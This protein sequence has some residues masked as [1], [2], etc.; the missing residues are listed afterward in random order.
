MLGRRDQITLGDDPSF[1]PSSIMPHFTINDD[2]SPCFVTGN[3]HSL[4]S[5]KNKSQSQLSPF[6]GSVELLPGDRSNLFIGLD[7]SQSPDVPGYRL[8]S[9]F[10]HS[11][12]VQNT[13]LPQT[14]DNMDINMNTNLFGALD[15]FDNFGGVEL[16]IDENGAVILDE[17]ELQLPV[18]GGLDLAEAE[19]PGQ[20]EYNQNKQPV[21]HGPEGD[22]PMLGSDPL[23]LFDDDASHLPKS[24][25]QIQSNQAAAPSRKRRRRGFNLDD[26]S[27]TL[28]R[29]VLKSWQEQYVDNAETATKRRKPTTAAQ[30]RNNA[31]FFILG[32]GIGGA[33]C[34]RGVSGVNYPLARFF[35]GDALRDLVFGLPCEEGQDAPTPSPKGRRRRAADAFDE[36]G[37]EGDDRNVRVR[38]Y[39]TPQQGRSMDEEADFAMMLGDESMPEMGMEAAEPM[40]EHMSS[41]L[42]PWNRTPSIGR[43]S[44]VIG[45][46]AQ[47]HEQ[48][49]RQKSASVRGSSIPPFE[50]LN[51]LQRKDLG[52]I[53]SD[54]IESHILGP[55][56]LQ[57]AGFV[58]D[59]QEEDENE[60]EWTRSNLESASREF[61][62]WTEEEAKTIGQVKEGD[63][64]ENRR[65]VDFD[66]L[67]EPTKQ[68]H[69]VAAQA[70]YHILSLATKNAISVEQEVEEMQAFGSIRIGVDMKAHLNK[71]E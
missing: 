15:D 22:V 54:M 20:P 4:G 58:A 12:S 62:L 36:A 25:D 69:V 60:S 19:V 26:E 56:G 30:A 21:V 64:N 63:R 68:N 32:Q 51:D 8:P 1:V 41:S 66:S 28:S 11:S 65:W 17:D 34:H 61:L 16:V 2:G 37:N 49:S 10:R 70:F 71:V 43:G 24:A 13:L 33:G 6:P 27:T 47:R 45:H 50:P 5:G 3:H 31:Y 38:V 9:P 42:M 53:H 14:H 40:D 35:S 44:S 48:G 55:E 18:L 52:E 57:S 29:S 7:I 39:E 67:V 23:L 46:S 59:A